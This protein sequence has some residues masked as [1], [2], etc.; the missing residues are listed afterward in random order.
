MTL[1][2]QLEMER[3]KKREKPLKNIYRAACRERKK[4]EWN[5]LNMIIIW[6]DVE[7]R[8]CKAV[9]RVDDYDIMT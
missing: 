1:K 7:I 8:N 4:R 5:D 6:Q 3:E 2:K 9:S